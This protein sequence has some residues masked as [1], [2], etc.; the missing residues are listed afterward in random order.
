[1]VSPPLSLCDYPQFPV[2]K[3]LIYILLK[4]QFALASDEPMSMATAFASHVVDWD[5]GP[6][7]ATAPLTL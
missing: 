2:S 4:S 3:N 7:F 6:S 5:R 1:M